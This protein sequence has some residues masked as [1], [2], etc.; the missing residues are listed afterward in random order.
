[1]QITEERAAYKEYKVF[2]RKARKG[3]NYKVKINNRTISI[4]I[5]NTGWPKFWNVWVIE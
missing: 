3:T 4:H 1:M 5:E 2:E